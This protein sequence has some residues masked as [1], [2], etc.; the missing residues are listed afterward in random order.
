MAKKDLKLN[1]KNSQLA[2]ALKLTKEK[3]AS[4]AV[5]K[6]APKKGSTKKSAAPTKEEPPKRK[7]RILKGPTSEAIPEQKPK[8]PELKEEPIS[9]LEEQQPPVKEVKVEK[10]EK[11]EVKATGKATEK[12]PETKKAPA[13]EEGFVQRKKKEEGPKDFHQFRATMKRKTTPKFDS[14][15]RM[16]LRDQDDSWR[17]K[18]PRMKRKSVSE[19]E[20]LRPKS[21]KV[22]LP[23]SIKDLAQE[24]KLKASQLISKLFMQGLT[25]T[26]NDLLDDE[27]TIQL[28]G[29]E[30]DC[31]ITIDTSEEERLRITGKSIKQEIGSTEEESLKP[32]SP[33]IAFMGHVDHGKTSLIDAIR[34]TNVVSTEAG[35]ITQHI[36]AFRSKTDLGEVT[37]LDTPGHEAFTQMRE[38]GAN[39]TDIVVLVVAGDEGIK[40]QTL[41]SIKQAQESKVPMVIA[42][43]KSDKPGF[44][45]Q[46]VYREL[47]DNNLLPE[48]WGG[49]VITVNTSATTGQGIKELLELVLLQAEVL[50][51]KANPNAR[52]RG[53]VLESQM[54]KGLGAVATLLVLNGTLKMSDALVVGNFS[55][56]IKTMHDE[57]EANLA[58]A[59]PSTPVKVTG[60]SDLPEAGSEF[61]VV[62]SEKEAR[63]LAADRARGE[64]QRAQQARKLGLE[65]LLESVESVKILPLILKADV[66]G[67]LEALKTSILKIKSKK[68][69]VEIV[70]EEVGE[71]SESDIELAAASGATII[72][73]HTRIESSA[74]NLAKQLS[75]NVAMYDVIYHAK[76]FV[77]SKM[78][79]LLDKIPEEKDIGKAEVKTVFKSSHLGNIAGCQ[80]IEGS[81]A[82]NHLVKILRKDEVVWKGKIASLKRVKEDVKEVQKGIECGI[83]LENNKDVQEGDIIQSYEIIYHTQKL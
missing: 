30:F 17:K 68:A 65:T 18:R 24:M 14:R 56:R 82:R 23:I 54:H 6:S 2:E 66:Q 78:V 73:F 25:F 19:E 53:I 15:D 28:L 52:A 70:G 51:L 26:L 67:S 55:G 16:G 74:D 36:G 50:E 80:V 34:K 22:R 59:P 33:I 45:E 21:L 61:I 40:E 7:A 64:K 8:P 72:G 27:T 79:E 4:A 20:V 47:S 81:I 38:R 46:K 48:A 12:T 1:I 9:T 42:I 44:D 69:R 13:K 10:P 62:G 31:D 43:N 63:K 49:T 71:I 77:E 57:H 39:V 32:R 29:Q 60:L 3:L 76:E 35:A 58:E 41:E 83:V 75:V 5:K 37:I 11:E